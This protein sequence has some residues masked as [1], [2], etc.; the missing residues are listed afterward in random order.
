[1][2]NGLWHIIGSISEESFKGLNPYSNGKWS[3]TVK[4]HYDQ[5]VKA[6]S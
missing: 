3:L 4:M 2:E 5:I 6:L 1:M